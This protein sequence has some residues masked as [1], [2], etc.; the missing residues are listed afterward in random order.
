MPGLLLTWF[1]SPVGHWPAHHSTARQPGAAAVDPAG[2]PG[3]SSR[4]ETRYASRQL[5]RHG[6]KGV[7]RPDLELS[8]GGEIVL[9][10]GTDCPGFRADT[11]G[12]PA[13]AGA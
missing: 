1:R 10:Y 11:A 6:W 4:R 7:A 12:E 9:W 3:G 8:V 5:R 13:C 2:S